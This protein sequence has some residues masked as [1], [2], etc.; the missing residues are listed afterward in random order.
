MSME[1]ITDSKQFS[2]YLSEVYKI[3][4][5]CKKEKQVEMPVVHEFAPGIYIRT[6][7]MPAGT[8][9]MGKSHKTE[10][11]NIIETG[12]CKLMMD[13]EMSIIEAPDRF[14]S[15]PGVKKILYIIDDM[16]WSTV[17]VT[18]ETDLKKLEAEH[19]MTEDEEKG[20]IEYF[21]TLKLT[22]GQI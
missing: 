15:K 9:V 11:F 12:K 10:H 18:G 2:D 20:M 5:F 7:F 3:Q 1:L 14:V 13:G 19:V 6:I 17:H 16:T 4:D 8:F 21:E 22:E